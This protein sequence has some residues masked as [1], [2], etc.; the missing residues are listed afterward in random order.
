MSGD[1]GQAALALESE[2]DL[3]ARHGIVR[4]PA[5]Q[6]HVGGFRYTNFAD[7]LAQARRAGRKEVA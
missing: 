7:A 2:V 3:M 6:F 1:S 4:V 5:D